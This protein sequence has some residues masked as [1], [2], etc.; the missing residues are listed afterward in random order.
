MIIIA[1]YSKY[2][3]HHFLDIQCIC[4]KLGDINFQ[5]FSCIYMYVKLNLYALM[6]KY[7]FS[8]LSSYVSYDTS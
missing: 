8:S 1:V 3:R 2:S 4:S 5:R 6:S 7:K